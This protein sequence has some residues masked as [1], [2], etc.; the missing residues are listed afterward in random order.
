MKND[1]SVRCGRYALRVGRVRRRALICRTA[2]RIAA[3]IISLILMLMPLVGCAART[4]G[5]SETEISLVATIFPPYDFARAVAGG[6]DGKVDIRMLLPPGSESHDYEPTVADIAEIAECD[7]FIC[8]GGETDRWVDGVM[9]AVGHSVRMLRLTD[10]TELLAE[11]DSGI[12]DGMHGHEHDDG[13][14]H[15]DGA[16]A[17]EHVWTSPAI[18]AHITSVICDAMCDIA[19]QYADSF[20]TSAEAYMTR[21]RDIDCRLVA[22]A[23]DGGT[24][25]FADR[26]PFRYLT[27][28]LGL[29][30]RAAF[31]GC[32]SDSEP[33][34]TAI[35]RLSEEARETGARVI[36]KGEFAD[37]AAAG[38]IADACGAHVMTLHSCHNVTRED[39]ESGVTY[40]QLM[41]ENLEVIRIALGLDA[42]L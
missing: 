4:G 28:E 35:Y 24:L 16:E 22:A 9:D 15:G 31:A 25:I 21:L 19:P 18:A 14:G 33:S 6:T 39:F 34:L 38:L 5:A 11:D 32:S 30:Y 23:R 27:H 40:A 42:A 26:F 12:V 41:E 2:G 3:A 17:D 13:D 36:L 20:R 37:P 7:L 8:V 1:V 29:D 10:M